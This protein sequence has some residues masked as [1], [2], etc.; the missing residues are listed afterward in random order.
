MAPKATPGRVVAS[1]YMDAAE[2]RAA[3]VHAVQRGTSASALVRVLLRR[4]L[5]APVD[6]QEAIEAEA[7]QL[8]QDRRKAD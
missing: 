6:V 1:I 2:W 5:A 7:R 3:R 4:H 8:D